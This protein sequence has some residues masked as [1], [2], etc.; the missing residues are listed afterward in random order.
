MRCAAGDPPRSITPSRPACGC[1]TDRVDHPQLRLGRDVGGLL[2][3]A[4]RRVFLSVYGMTRGPAFTPATP[5]SSASARPCPVRSATCGSGPDRTSASARHREGAAAALDRDARPRART[6]GSWGAAPAPGVL[7]PAYGCSTSGGQTAL[8]ALLDRIGARAFRRAGVVD[9]VAGRLHARG[10]R[11][12]VRRCAGAFARAGIEAGT[13]WRSGSARTPTGSPGSSARCGPGSPSSCWIPAWRRGL[14]D[15]CR[16]AGV[17]DGHGRCRRNHRRN[18]LLR[19]SRPDVASLPEPRRWRGPMDDLAIPGHSVAAA[20]PPCRRRCPSPAPRLG[21]ALVCSRRARPGRR[22][23]WCTPRRASPRRSRAAGAGGARPCRPGP[24]NG[25]PPHLARRCWRGRRW[26]SR[27]DGPDRALARRSP[28]AGVS[29]VTLPLHRAR[30]DG[31]R[32]RGLVRCRPTGSAAPRCETGASR[33][34][35]APA[36]RC[37]AALR[38]DR[39]PPGLR[40]GADDRLAHDE[41]DGDL[42]GPPLDGVRVRT[43][44]D[45]ELHVAGPALARGYLG[46]A[47]PATELPTGDLGRLDADGPARAPGPPQGDAHPRRRE[48]LSRGCTSRRSAAAA[49]ARRRDDGRAARG[50]GRDRRPVRRAAARRGPGAGGGGWRPWPARVPAGPH[51]RP[52]AVL[53]IAELPRA[54]RSG[55]PD[56]AALPPRGRAAR[57]RSPGPDAR[58]RYRRDR[59]RRRGDRSTTRPRATTSSHSVGP[60]C[61]PSSSLAYSRG[62]SRCTTPAPPVLAA[63]D[64]VVHAAAHVAPWGP[65]DHSSTGDRR[66]LGTRSD[67]SHPAARLVVIGTASVYD[68]RDPHLAHH[69]A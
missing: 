60:T 68:P 6:C 35:G 59:L 18:G 51:A 22:A 67:S 32:R 65:T 16:V 61:P 31:S 39:T 20:R 38:H 37:V 2:V 13:R 62:T 45:G 58:R 53:G 50:R 55:K 66:W 36:E 49:R 69:R 47:M 40:V 23:A 11:R 1:D 63:C 34:G 8:E 42:V 19:P 43:D 27:R 57:R 44:E 14:A 25:S 7:F 41:R 15:R 17:R 29:H 5:K 52:D 64:A 56:S 9:A 3:P 30:V 48:H 4:G 46:E 10:A 24:G 54:G 12:A 28:A 21:P 33:A 26:S